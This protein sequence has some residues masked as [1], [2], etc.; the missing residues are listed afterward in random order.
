MTYLLIVTL[1]II[2]LL[3]LL[4]N[5]TPSKIEKYSRN[6]ENDKEISLI[7]CEKCGVYVPADNCILR[8]GKYYCKTCLDFNKS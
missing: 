8:Q 3:I 5:K 6:H 7:P 1:V 2:A 4:K